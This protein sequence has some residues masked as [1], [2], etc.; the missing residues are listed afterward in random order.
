M[1]GVRDVFAM[2]SAQP[3]AKHRKRRGRGSKNFVAI[4]VTAAITLGTLANNTVVKG[5]LLG[6][7][8]EDLYVISADL[9]WTIRSLTVGEGPIEVGVVHSD[10]TVT[11]ILENLD[12]TLLG[13]GTKIEQERS[14]RLVRRIGMFNGLGSEEVLNDGQ[15][16]RTKMRFTCQDGKDLD[17][18]VRNSSGATLITGAIVQ[19]HG[20]VYGR[21]ML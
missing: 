9:I 18:W 12:V 4:P 20:T 11:E 10:Y 17:A 7:L 8:L 21:W 2:Q 16:I 14:R 1:V 6:T 5:S 13:P 3:M 15:V 19:V